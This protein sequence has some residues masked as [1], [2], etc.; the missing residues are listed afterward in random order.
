MPT[1]RHPVGSLPLALQAPTQNKG[2][3]SDI[4]TEKTDRPRPSGDSGKLRERAA[5]LL[6]VS[7]N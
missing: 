2:T 5:L 6:D 4:V 1:R 3:E 7:F